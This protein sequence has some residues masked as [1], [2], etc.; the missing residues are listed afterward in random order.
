MIEVIALE[1]QVGQIVYS[2]DGHDKGQTMMVLSVEDRY[3]YLANGKTRMLTKPKRKK[4]IHV[5]PI[6]YVDAVMAEKLTQ[7]EYVLDSDIRKAIKSYQ[8]K[9]ADC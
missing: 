5:Q 3:L 2:K 8:E 6:N 9:A 7:N 1:F 4:I